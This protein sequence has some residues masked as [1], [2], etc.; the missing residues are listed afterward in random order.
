MTSEE[1]ARLI[2]AAATGPVVFKMSGRDRSAMYALALGTGFRAS[3][4]LSLTPECFDLGADP[5]TVTCDAAHSK[6]RRRDSQPIRPDLAQFLAPWLAGKPPGKALFAVSV[7]HT[8]EML[9]TDLARAGIDY[10]D[11]SGRVIDFHAIRH[12][13]VSMLAR[14]P[15]S[16]KAVQTLARHSTPVLTLA[17]YTHLGIHDQ[18]AALDALPPIG[19][20]T[21]AARTAA[22][23]TDGRIKTSGDVLAH[24][25]PTEGAGSGRELS[26][27]AAN[28]DLHL[29][30][31]DDVL[32]DPQPLEMSAVNAPRHPLSGPVANGGGGIR[33]HGRLLT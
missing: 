33:T 29:S 24:Y 1:I 21:E 8:A 10:A 7:N 14:G 25:L 17:T 5:P 9:R 20:A 3:E 6:R 19:G 13:Y 15:A 22:T 11:A 27:I 2:D 26:V 28:D 18:T 12:T 32:A 16:V 30:S 23:G 4:V 31:H